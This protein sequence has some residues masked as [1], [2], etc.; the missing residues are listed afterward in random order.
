VIQHQPTE[1]SAISWLDKGRAGGIVDTD[2]YVGY[3]ARGIVRADALLIQSE[4][5]FTRDP[6]Y[7]Q[8]A[9][10]NTQQHYILILSRMKDYTEFGIQWLKEKKPL[11]DA[12]IQK[13]NND[14]NILYTNGDA[15]VYSYFSNVTSEY[16]FYYI[17]DNGRP[18]TG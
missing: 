6:G 14:C 7:P 1:I 9:D 8:R 10:T 4:Y 16:Y 13:I 17:R 11:S 2:A 5:P 18:P 15:K 3:A 12:E